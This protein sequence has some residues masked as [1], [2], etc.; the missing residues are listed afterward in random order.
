MSSSAPKLQS[1]AAAVP[2]VGPTSGPP[3][4]PTLTQTHGET[5]GET[6]AAAAPFCYVEA[7][8]GGN[9]SGLT[10]EQA[11]E[12]RSRRQQA[13]ALERGREAGRQELRSSVD[14]AIASGRQQ[15]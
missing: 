11:E 14:V 3:S 12:E 13:E 9:V 7:Q 6:E 1:E 2:P 4:R 10:A 8:P 5:Y 15:I